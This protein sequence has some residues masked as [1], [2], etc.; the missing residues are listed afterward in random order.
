MFWPVSSLT[1]FVAVAGVRASGTFDTTF[2]VAKHA[3]IS[4]QFLG[5][6]DGAFHVYS[7]TDTMHFLTVGIIDLIENG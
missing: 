5:S 7:R 1:V 4:P 3:D 2:F 6:L